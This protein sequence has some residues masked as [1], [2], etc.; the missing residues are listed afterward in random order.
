MHEIY[1][2]KSYLLAAVR[3]Y[4]SLLLPVLGNRIFYLLRKLSIIIFPHED[5]LFRT[6]KVTVEEKVSTK[7]AEN[8]CT[9][10]TLVRIAH[11][12]VVC[13]WSTHGRDAEPLRRSKV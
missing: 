5:R 12:N 11:S 8:H 6:Q 2:K 10:G 1:K 13:W 4:D 3:V 9:H 7:W